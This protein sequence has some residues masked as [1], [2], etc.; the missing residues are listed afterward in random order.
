MNEWSVAKGKIGEPAEADGFGAS[1]G[2][3]PYT[4]F[5]YRTKRAATVERQEERPERG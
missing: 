4:T 3:V 1:Q 2:A 5:V